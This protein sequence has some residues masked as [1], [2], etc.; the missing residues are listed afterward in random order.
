MDVEDQFL[1]Y[2]FREQAT[3]LLRRSPAQ[4]LHGLC[5]VFQIIE[6]PSLQEETSWEVCLNTENNCLN[7]TVVKSQWKSIDDSRRFDEWITKTPL[8]RKHSPLPPPTFATQQFALSEA[9]VTEAVHR[10]QQFQIPLW[11]NSEHAGLDGTSY[12]LFVDHIQYSARFHWW[13]EPPTPWQPLHHFAQEALSYFYSLDKG[14][15]PG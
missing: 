9:W 12:E 6:L 1:W 7:H 8:Q 4:R 14:S 2:E 3:D 10:I 5:V 13:E 15:F 11:I